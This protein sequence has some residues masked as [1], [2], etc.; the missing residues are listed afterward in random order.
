MF[1]NNSAFNQDIGNW[2]VEN[3]T[4]CSG[5]IQGASAW[6]LLLPQLNFTNCNPN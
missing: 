6:M 5:F 3:V 1:Q 4:S 2:N